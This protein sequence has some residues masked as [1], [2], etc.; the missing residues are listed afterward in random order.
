MPD[1]NQP[2]AQ[3]TEPDETTRVTEK[4]LQVV[5]DQETKD[6]LVEKDADDT[7][8]ADTDSSKE[9]SDTIVVI[10]PFLDKI[11]D[12]SLEDGANFLEC[13]ILTYL[14]P[15]LKL[16]SQKVLTQQD[17][18]APSDEDRADRIY[19]L[20]QLQWASECTKARKQ[21]QELKLK[22]KEAAKKKKPTKTKTT[23]TA[24][25]SGAADATSTKSKTNTKTDSLG[26]ANTGEDDDC[27]VVPDLGS[28]LLTSFSTWR[29]MWAVVL[30]MLSALLQFVP[31]QLLNDLVRYFE[32]G[33]DN[34][35]LMF[36][37]PW[38]EVVLLGVVPFIASLLQTQNSVIMTHCAVFV[39][40]GC[41][42]LLYNKS[43][44]ISA[45]ARA[46]TS[47]GQVVNMMSNNTNQLQRF[48]QFSGN[49]LVAP[50]QI[51][52]ALVLIYQQVGNA[53]WVGVAYMVSLIPAN[54]FIFRVV[55]KMRFK[56]L[57]LS[58]ARVKMMNEVLM[59][60]RI[61][62][63]YARE[64]PFGKQVNNLRKKELQ[65]LTKLTYVS[66]IGF[67]VILMSAP[68]IQP[69]LVC[70]STFKTIH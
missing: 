2:S 1:I 70:I 3:L 63:F 58:D 57:K 25:V 20:V 23:A 19:R 26:N 68:I 40:T 7:D 53:M 51:I 52:L 18:G 21:M 62:K 36:K 12:H 15:L 41:S 33:G 27:I 69:I 28:A 14:S 60:I 50:L 24:V 48:L 64:Q 17:V 67:S 55:G 49:F 42:T 39:K 38:I 59:G 46:R 31:V 5:L 45:T 34:D 61:I 22:K 56:V 9:P 35:N 32:Q 54:I 44:T 11:Q 30:Y 37:N 8:D 10:N 16:G 65:A 47:T 13:W 4:P 29:F 43:L 6:I 66:Q